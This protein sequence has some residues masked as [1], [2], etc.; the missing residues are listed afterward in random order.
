MAEFSGARRRGFR[1]GWWGAAVAHV[2]GNM[3]RRSR[4][5][6]ALGGAAKVT[7]RATAR[8]GHLLW[9]EVTGL[10]FVA[11]AAI[12]ALAVWHN[13]SKYKVLSGRLVAAICFMVI[14][15]WFGVSSFYRARQKAA[16]EGAPHVPKDKDRNSSAR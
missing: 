7:L 14:F 11:F 1:W 5:V 16:P 3:V 13:Y 2:G 12:G 15:A 9:L 4:T 8:V 6:N 10:L